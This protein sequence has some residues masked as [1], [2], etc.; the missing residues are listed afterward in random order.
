MRVGCVVTADVTSRRRR[1][2]GETRD[3]TDHLITWAPPSL[4]A[5]LKHR[6]C[7]LGASMELRPGTDV[8]AKDGHGQTPLSWAVMKGDEAIIQLLES[9]LAR[10]PL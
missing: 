5:T 3:R 4:T 10:L 6:R 9:H 8:E 1:L 2:S 7:C